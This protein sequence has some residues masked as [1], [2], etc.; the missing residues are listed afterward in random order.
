MLNV[1]KHCFPAE[2]ATWRPRLREMIPSHD[3]R[4]HE[5]PALLD[6]IRAHTARVLGLP[7]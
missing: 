2:Y 3:I 6:E 7:G 1:I 4:L 5:T